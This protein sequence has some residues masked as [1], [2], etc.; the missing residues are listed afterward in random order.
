MSWSKQYPAISPQNY[1][2]SLD[3]L[4]KTAYLV[5][6]AVRDALL[7]RDR[8]DLDLD[9]DFVVFENAIAI[10]R[11]IAKHY[12]AG[13]VVLDKD[14]Q[15]ARVV[16]D[17]ATVDIALAEGKSQE[18]DLRRRD[19]TINAIAYNPHRDELIDPLEGR[20]DLTRKIVKMVSK[21]NLEDDPLRLLRAYRQAAQLNFTIEAKTRS[22]IRDLSTSINRVASERVR[23][24]LNYLL[25]DLNGTDWLVAAIGDGLLKPWLKH[26]D[27]KNLALLTKIDPVIESLKEIE[28]FNCDIILTKLASLVSKLPAEAEL[29][30]NNLKYS[31]I[32][33][34]TVTTALRNLSQLE[35][36]NAPMTLKEEYFFFLAVGD[37]LPILAVLAISTGVDRRFIDPLIKRY[38]DPQDLVA[39]PQSLITGNDL[40]EVL[41]IK[42]SRQIGLLLTEIQLA[43]I[44]GKIS[45]KAEALELAKVIYLDSQKNL[46]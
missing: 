35:Q 40:I 44:A 5:G 7:L 16:F 4:P 34:R 2:F 9:L 15:I 39:H 10:A 11:Q 20:L 18:M 21:S 28:S 38:L 36:L 42:P 27:A 1:P 3:F 37:V 29:E 19:F 33:I 30:L 43:F 41:K 22:T 8:G 31:R 25:K 14:R 45:T 32:E 12:R 26:T 46:E 23:S 6:G 17:R 24:E 13:F